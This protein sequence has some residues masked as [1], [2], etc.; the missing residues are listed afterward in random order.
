MKK[1]HRGGNDYIY[2]WNLIT[3]FHQEN[4]YTEIFYYYIK[5]I[6]EQNIIVK[7]VDFNGQVVY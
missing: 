4:M 2:I 5:L 3:G 6:S 7:L 1:V